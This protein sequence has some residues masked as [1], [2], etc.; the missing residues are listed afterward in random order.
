MIKRNKNI[1]NDLSGDD[2]IG[3][4]QELNGLEQFIY[5]DEVFKKESEMMMSFGDKMQAKRVSKVVSNSSF[6]NRFKQSM[7]LMKVDKQMETL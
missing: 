3:F 1:F 5:N 7:A 4:K 6:M 2:E